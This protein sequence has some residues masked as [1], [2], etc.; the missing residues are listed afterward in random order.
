MFTRLMLSLV[1]TGT[2][3]ESFYQLDAEGKR[4]R[5]HYDGLPVE[6]IA[7]AISTLGAQ[8][9]ENG[10]LTY[11]VM[12][13]YDDGLGLDEFI[14]WLIEAGYSIERI[15]DYREW[16]QRF[17][18][19]LRALPERQRQHSL[20]LL[21]LLPPKTAGSHQRIDGI[22]RSFPRLGARSESRPEQ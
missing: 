6:F 10:F 4:Q 2:A 9:S 16:L 14:D 3:P 21:L 20:L 22:H 12:N 5:A 17:E 11:H 18:T 19:T 8:A 1:A 13:P 7:E 15:A